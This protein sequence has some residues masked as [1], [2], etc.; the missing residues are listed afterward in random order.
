VQ[1]SSFKPGSFLLPAATYKNRKTNN[2]KDV[3]LLGSIRMLKTPLQ[4]LKTVR[5]AK[6]LFE[7]RVPCALPEKILTCK[8][9]I[10][11]APPLVRNAQ[12]KGVLAQQK[13]QV[14]CKQTQQTLDFRHRPRLNIASDQMLYSPNMK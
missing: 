8:L 6:H 1:L 12:Q 11:M 3:H 14:D 2:T 4:A 10:V 13:C 7:V 9:K 5:L